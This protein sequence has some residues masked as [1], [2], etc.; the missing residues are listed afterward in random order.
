[1]TRRRYP[2]WLPGRAWLLVAL[3]FMTT[4]WIAQGQLV[5]PTERSRELG[6]AEIGPPTV[7][8]V[9]V[10]VSEQYYDVEAETLTEVV[11]VLNATRIGGPTAPRSQGLTEYTIRPEWTAS[12]SGG[13]CHVRAVEVFVDITITLPRWPVVF[14]RPS[15]D[16]EGWS[17]IDA[18]IREHE[19]RHRDLTID[20]A[21]DVLEEIR[22]LDAAGCTVLRRVVT[23][24]LSVADQRLGTAHREVDEST[25]LRLSIGGPG[26]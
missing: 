11:A 8:G 24:T 12:A 23:S 9:H 22:G 21:A 16:R 6:R 25:P 20:A 19:Y 17:R 3:G 5:P 15:S 2:T 1:M 14:D 4:P 13:R 10:S 26:G 7:P 18:A